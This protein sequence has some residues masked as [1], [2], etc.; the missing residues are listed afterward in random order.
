[1]AVEAEVEAAVGV[2]QEGGEDL[3]IEDEEVQGE[4]Q[5]EAVSVLAEVEVEVVILTLQGLAVAFADVGHD[6]SSLALWR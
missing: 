5:E 6:F 3:V 1:V 2:L 4:L